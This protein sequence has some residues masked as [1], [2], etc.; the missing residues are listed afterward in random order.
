MVV[1]NKITILNPVFGPVSDGERKIS[2]GEEE[3]ELSIFSPLAIV[4]VNTF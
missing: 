1:V 3:S 2:R 4:K